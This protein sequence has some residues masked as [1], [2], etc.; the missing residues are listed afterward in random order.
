MHFRAQN[1]YFLYTWSRKERFQ[2][3]S[4]NLGV[5]RRF[6]GQLPCAN[7]T[8]VSFVTIEVLSLAREGRRHMC[9]YIDIYLYTRIH[10]YVYM[11]V[12]IYIYTYTC[13][14]LYS[15]LSSPLHSR[16][17]AALVTESWPMKKP[18]TSRRAEKPPT[19]KVALSAGCGVPESF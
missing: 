8:G 9:R 12:Y 13:I 17:E 4:A 5:Q 1:T 6:K 7:H 16:V 2:W 14:H 10:T 11:C 19:A 15:E 18:R 3:A